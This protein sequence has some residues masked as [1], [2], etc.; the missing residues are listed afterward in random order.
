MATVPSEMTYSA[1]SVLTGAQLN[2]NLRNAVN[3]LIATPLAILR[4]TTL[5]AITSSTWTSIL[6]DTED[7]DRDGMHST[8]TNTSRATAVTA[9]YYLPGGKVSF[10]SNSTARRWTRWAINGTEVPAARI[11][12]Q[13]ANG[14]ATEV[15]AASRWVYLNVGDYLELQGFQDSGGSLN[16]VV[17]NTGDQPFFNLQWMST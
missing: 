10:A 11:N 17:T 8:V 9:G 6:L 16:T 4:Q 2:S 12:E 7:I 15:P 13:A 1:G 5:Q 14:D 3:F